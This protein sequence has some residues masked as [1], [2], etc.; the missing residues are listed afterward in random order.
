[1]IGRTCPGRILIKTIIIKRSLAKEGILPSS[2]GKMVEASSK[3]PQV[4]KQPG[5][6]PML[7]FGQANSFYAFKEAISKAAVEQFRHDGTHFESGKL[8][9]PE[10]PDRMDYKSVEN[11]RYN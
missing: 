7:Q 11:D 8:Y 1:M 10:V 5:E 3:T 9:K 4:R 2:H 6:V